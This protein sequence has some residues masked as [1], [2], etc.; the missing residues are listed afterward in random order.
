MVWCLVPREERL[1][2][3]FGNILAGIPVVSVN[4]LSLNV[5]VS[6]LRGV[7]TFVR[8]EKTNPSFYELSIN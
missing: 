1:S 5:R 4:L 3:I 8:Y 7:L 6:V 2:R